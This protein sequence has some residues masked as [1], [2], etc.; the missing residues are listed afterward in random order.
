[1]K[2]FDPNLVHR[3]P[4]YRS[5]KIHRPPTALNEYTAP[6]YSFI[7]LW[8]REGAISPPFRTTG[9]ERPEAGATGCG[10]CGP[11][12]PSLAV[13]GRRCDRAPTPPPPA[14]P[15]RRLDRLSYSSVRRRTGPPTWRQPRDPG[16]H[17]P[18][19]GASRT[20]FE[21]SVLIASGRTI[22]GKPTRFSATAAHG[23]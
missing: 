19:G 23:E 9:L 14:M 20:R 12:A 17:P 8:E 13:I 11:P 18:G 7:A 16:G 15:R 10:T 3:P 4:H 5:K 2:Y 1:M 21:F 22:P 6:Q